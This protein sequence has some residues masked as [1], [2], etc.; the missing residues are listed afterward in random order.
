[1]ASRAPN[2]FHSRGPLKGERGVDEGQMREPLREDSE[3]G[4][5]TRIDLLSQQPDI[6]DE[7]YGLV[8]QIGGLVARSGEG[9]SLHE[10]ESAR[11][12]PNGNRP[13]P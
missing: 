1:M 2:S 7:L 10:A 11:D 13:L 12:G 6:V 9:E 5:G 4:T 8:H 3:K